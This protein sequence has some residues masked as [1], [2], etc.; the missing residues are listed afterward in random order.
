MPGSLWPSAISPATILPK[1]P[2]ECVDQAPH[3]K[4]QRLF[5]GQVRRL[6]QVGAIRSQSMANTNVALVGHHLYRA[7]LPTL[8]RLAISSAN[9]QFG[10]SSDGRHVGRLERPD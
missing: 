5:R 1:G 7:G 8:A 2:V 6:L 9:R 10:E 4:P 3:S